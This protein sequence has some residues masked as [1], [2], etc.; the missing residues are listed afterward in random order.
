MCVNVIYVCCV[1][2]VDGCNESIERERGICESKATEKNGIEGREKKKK[3]ERGKGERG[4]EG[5]TK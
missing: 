1:V 5:R 3:Q 4:G 2:L